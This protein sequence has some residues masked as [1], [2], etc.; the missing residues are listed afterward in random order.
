ML[1]WLRCNFF[2]LLVSVVVTALFGWLLTTGDSLR[3]AFLVHAVENAR[4]ITTL[5]ES[6]A[7]QQQ[8]ITLLEDTI[9]KRLSRIEDKLDA[10]LMHLANTKANRR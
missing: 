10:V 4:E 6:V 1:R 9:D 7:T 5:Q 8:R 3:N 2:P